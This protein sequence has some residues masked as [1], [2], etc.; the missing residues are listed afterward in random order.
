MKLVNKYNTCVVIGTIT[1]KDIYV[2]DNLWI[3]VCPK[4]VQEFK[5][6]DTHDTTVGMNL[7][8]LLLIADCHIIVKLTFSQSMS[9]RPCLSE[10]QNITKD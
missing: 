8:L 10:L 5:L 4:L 9:T 3:T 6:P 7:S 1:L 2:D